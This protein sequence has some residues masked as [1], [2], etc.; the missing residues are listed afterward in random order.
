MPPPPTFTLSNVNHSPGTGTNHLPHST[1]PPL[2]LSSGAPKAHITAP[3][4]PHTE[5]GHTAYR[6]AANFARTVTDS[7]NSRPPMKP[8]SGSGNN[9]SGHNGQDKQNGEEE[10]KLSKGAKIG[11][12]LG[13]TVVVVGVGIQ[14]ARTIGDRVF[15]PTVTPLSRELLWCFRA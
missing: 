9:S 5:Q 7:S 14:S 11:I 2:T 8:T 1:L 12:G 10:G 13:A 4:A 15:G 3:S 6:E